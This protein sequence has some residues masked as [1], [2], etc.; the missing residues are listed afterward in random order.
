MKR[1]RAL[2]VA[3]LALGLA[4]A[5]LTACL[6]QSATSYLQS[7]DKST[8]SG[9]LDVR[10]DLYPAPDKYGKVGQPQR[11][12]AKLLFQ[13]P[14]RFRMVLYPGQKNEYRAVAEAGIVRWLDL[15]TGFSGKDRIDALVDPLAVALLG[16]AGELARF[17]G[18]KDLPL[19]K[20]SKLL[21]ASLTPKG[22]GSSVTQGLVWL[23]SDGQPIGYE[24]RLAD[25]RRMF[26]AVLTFQRNLQLPPDTWKL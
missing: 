22:W 16:T 23:S 17:S 9:A 13:R 1:T 15:S 11:Y 4:S 18:A 25:G 26:V 3:A 6:A 21:G 20:G 10:V 14:D 2:I 24:F 12:P 8:W 19:A 5:P 7:L